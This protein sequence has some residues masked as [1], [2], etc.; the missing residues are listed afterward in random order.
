MGKLQGADQLRARLRAIREVFKPIGRDWADETVVL[1]KAAVPVRT[2]NLKRSI[3]RRN[4]SMRKATVV[5]HFT[6]YFV[7]AGTAA[8]VV[9]PRR[10]RV[11]SDHNNVYGRRASIPRHA[12]RPF[13]ARVARQALERKPMAQT[14]IR[15][16]NAAGGFGGLR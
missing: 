14:V 12:P 2:G 11:L 1:A 13:R 9:R 4:A 15:A 16:W 8:H 7:D 3:R 5:A 10:A 6:Q